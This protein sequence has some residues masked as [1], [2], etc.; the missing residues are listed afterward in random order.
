MAKAV[1][2][3][4]WVDY[5]VLALSVFLVFC[6]L[7]ETFIRLPPLVA[8]MGK[9]HPLV[10]HFPIVL[11]VLTAFLGLTNKPIPNT[12]LQVAVISA[13][14]TAIS[15][16][17]LGMETPEKGNLLF[18]HQYAGS[19]LALLAVV[20][21]AVNKMGRQ[22][23]LFSKML[24][25]VMV[26]LVFFT[27]HY[28]GMVTHGEDF[29]ALPT[30][31]AKKELPEDPLIYGDVV[32]AI[33]E[34][35]CISCHNPNKQKG[36]LLMTNLP[37]MLKGGKSGSSILPGNSGGSELIRR[38]YLPKEDDAHMPPTGKKPLNENEINILE[39]WI[40]LGASD[41]LKLS[42]LDK[43]E[44]LVG[45]L[46][47]LYGPDDQA[48]W[49]ELPKVADTT[50]TRLS[51]DYMTVQRISKGSNALSVV[52][53]LPP[54]YVP[55]E[56]LKLGP[57]AKNIV[58]LD[59]SGL[60]LGEVEMALVGQCTNLRRLEVDRTP[61]QTSD[62]ASIASLKKL[63]FL[64][65]YDTAVNDGALS[66]FAELNSLKQIYLWNSEISSAA[67]EKFEQNHQELTVNK[68]IHSEL[69]PFFISKDSLKNDEQ[70]PS[71][72]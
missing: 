29:L 19:G 14:A 24:Q 55:E 1:K 6:L 57:V 42:H 27:G 53:F 20:W 5:V 51:T 12:L 66:V 69:M 47:S 4:T 34:A 13:L 40:A 25:V 2:N 50:L 61:L 3:R 68:G 45:L 23:H 63:E 16:F 15:G 26:L 11:L 46:A 64:K 58:E 9:W 54:N 18:W 44:P 32:H 7:F 10:L 39:R 22:L 49:A 17:F 71:V 21:Y 59:L 37:A 8:W 35:N 43:G 52:V 65:I 67:L 28:G 56:I 30:K 48:E 62:I 60:P 33:L 31:K 38:L 36:Q 72:E 70:L 41:T